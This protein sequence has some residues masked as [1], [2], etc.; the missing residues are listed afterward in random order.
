MD[1]GFGAAKRPSGKRPP[2]AKPKVRAL[3][4]EEAA[5][6]AREVERA[7]ALVREVGEA[8]CARLEGRAAALSQTLTGEGLPE[9]PPLP[10]AERLKRLRKAAAGLKVKPAKGRVK[11]LARLEA[12]LTAVEEAL[13]P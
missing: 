1:D 9:I 10:P 4:R 13:S 12:F 6:L 3:K 8:V 7:R 5:A 2:R 11:D